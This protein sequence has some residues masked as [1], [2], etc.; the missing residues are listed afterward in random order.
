MG[1][2]QCCLGNTRAGYPGKYHPVQYPLSGKYRE[3]LGN[4][5]NLLVFCVTRLDI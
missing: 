3:I 1:E 4:I 5:N 2:R